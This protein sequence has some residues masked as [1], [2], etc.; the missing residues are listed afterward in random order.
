MNA[1]KQ[2]GRQTGRAVTQTLPTPA[3][4]VK[5]QTFVPWTLVRRG[6]K[7][8]VITPPGIEQSFVKDSGRQSGAPAEKED[9]PLLRALGLAHHWQRLLEEGRVASLTEIAE[10]E[11][12][13]LAQASK[14]IRLTQLAPNLVEAMVMTRPEVSVSR[15]LRCG[16]GFTWQ[17]QGNT[18]DQQGIVI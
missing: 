2:V 11:G 15:L 3:G 5:L 18:L 17:T 8:E 10:A 7:K 13:D 9:T 16:W 1:K 4:G 6:L 12:I 14:I